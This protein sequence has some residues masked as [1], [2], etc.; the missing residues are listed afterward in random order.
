MK[1]SDWLFLH[2]PSSCFYLKLRFWDWT[3]SPSLDKEATQLGQ[4]ERASVMMMMMMMTTT[5]YIKISCLMNKLYIT[6]V[7]FL[8]LLYLNVSQ[9]TSHSAC[10]HSLQINGSHSRFLLHYQSSIQHNNLPLQDVDFKLQ[11]LLK[12]HWRN[13]CHLQKAVSCV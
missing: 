8:E 4:I 11:M 6:I 2:Y 10:L 5:M 1:Y 13:S 12:R 7:G 3:P 9:R